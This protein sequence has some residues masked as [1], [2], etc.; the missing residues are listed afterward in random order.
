MVKSCVLSLLL[1][2]TRKN[3]WCTF[4][5]W[6]DILLIMDRLPSKWQKRFIRMWVNL[7]PDFL[8]II[9]HTSARFKVVD[10]SLVEWILPNF[11]TTSHT[12]TIV[13]AVMMMATLKKYIYLSLALCFQPLI[14]LKILHFHMFSLVCTPLRHSR[15]QKIRL[16]SSRSTRQVGHLRRRAKDLCV[17]PTPYPYPFCWCLHECWDWSTSRSWLLGK[18]LP[19]TA[20]RL[21][22]NLSQR[23]D[24]RILCWG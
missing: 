22:F 3:W 20:L 9:T 1:T 5:M 17:P 8:L 6:I 7:Y 21:R 13:S 14:L 19:H 4:R 10:K 2:R 12:D 11:S 18:D 23:M 16:G 15:R 24:N